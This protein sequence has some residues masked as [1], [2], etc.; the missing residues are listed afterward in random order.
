MQLRRPFSES[1]IGTEGQRPH[2]QTC[3]RRPSSEAVLDSSPS[4]PSGSQRRAT[5]ERGSYKKIEMQAPLEQ[6]RATAA[7]NCWRETQ[8]ALGSSQTDYKAA[9]R[10]KEERGSYRR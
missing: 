7:Q 6:G 2:D 4:G 3:K 1:D 9:K 8:G 5:G 10:P